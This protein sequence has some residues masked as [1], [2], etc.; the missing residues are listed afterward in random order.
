MLNDKLLQFVDIDLHDVKD[1]RKRFD[2]ASLLYDQVCILYVICC[3]YLGLASL[4]SLIDK[5]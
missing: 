3:I 4:C 2:K 1:A 5:V